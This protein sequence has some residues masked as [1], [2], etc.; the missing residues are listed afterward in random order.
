MS[1]SN[2]KQTAVVHC[3]VLDYLM[4]L[5]FVVVVVVGLLAVL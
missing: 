4:L 5:V 3:R 1:F 2:L